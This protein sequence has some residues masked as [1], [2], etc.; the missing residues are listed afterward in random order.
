M[1]D[2]EDGQVLISFDRGRSTIDQQLIRSLSS[3]V[4]CIDG[5]H[6]IERNLCHADMSNSRANSRSLR[7]HRIVQCPRSVRISLGPVRHLVHTITF[8][9]PSNES[10]S[11][12]PLRRKQPCLHQLTHYTR[13]VSAGFGWSILRVEW[14]RI[15]P[16][17]KG[18][19]HRPA[20]Q[21]TL[22][23]THSAIDRWQVL[24]TILSLMKR[25][26]SLRHA[27]MYSIP[28]RDSATTTLAGLAHLTSGEFVDHHMPRTHSRTKVPG[29]QSVVSHT[30]GPDCQKYFQRR[31]APTTRLPIPGKRS[32]AFDRSQDVE[33]VPDGQAARRKLRMYH[34]TLLCPR[35]CISTLGG[36]SPALPGQDYLDENLLHFGLS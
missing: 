23:H 34:C 36:I 29:W 32:E 6:Q 8:S 28:R 4:Y 18:K 14:T 1:G 16:A 21:P 5:S 25:P 3:H 10:V 2:A 30:F 11:A 33:K 17:M 27:A 13:N 20:C 26:T 19:R 7:A 22:T 15:H 9:H 24:K 12:Q 35:R 31:A